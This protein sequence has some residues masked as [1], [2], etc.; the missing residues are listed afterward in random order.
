MSIYCSQCGQA[1]PDDARFCIRCG[2]KVQIPSVFITP[3]YLDNICDL[4]ADTI[5]DNMA[6]GGISLVSSKESAD[7]ISSR[8][9]SVQT[10]SDL[11]AFL[12]ELSDNWPIFQSVTEQILQK[13]PM[14]PPA[15][16]PKLSAKQAEELEQEVNQIYEVGQHGEI[17]DEIF[18]RALTI[19]DDLEGKFADHPKKDSFKT[20]LIPYHFARL[21]LDLVNK[22]WV[23]ERLQRQ[24]T[25]PIFLI[26]RTPQVVDDYRFISKTR[27]AWEFIDSLELPD[28]EIRLEGI[29]LICPRLLIYFDLKIFKKLFIALLMERIHPQKYEKEFARIEQKYGR[30]AVQLV[31]ELTAEY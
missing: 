31:E 4:L 2:T 16:M 28:V 14:L 9:M 30:Y 24:K 7:F 20:Y 25:N 26:G 6:E 1:L 3:E 18:N 5:L 19:Y 12:Q 15:P 13:Y 27:F 17:T 23:D 22:R 10:K 29:A 11:A 21:A 8:I